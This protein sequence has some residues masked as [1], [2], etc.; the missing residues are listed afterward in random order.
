MLEDPDENVWIEKRDVRRP[1][2]KAT[3][4]TSAAPKVMRATGKDQ[5]EQGTHDDELMNE[6]VGSADTGDGC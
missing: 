4:G 2:G 5:M 1:T 6:V 3:S